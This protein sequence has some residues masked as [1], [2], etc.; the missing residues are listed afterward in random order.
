MIDI[1]LLREN[2]EVIK[3]ALKNRGVDLDVAQLLELDKKK[4]GMI[5]E[6]ENL[7]A[8][9]NEIS[10]QKEKPADL[11]KAKTIKEELKKKE[12]ELENVEKQFDSLFMLI[13]NIPLDDVPIGKSEKD[14]KVIREWGKIPKFDFEIKDHLELGKQLNL[15]DIKRAAKISGSRFGILKNEAVLLEF[16]L[17]QFAF[18]TLLKQGFTLIVPPTLLKTEMMKGMGYIDTK[19]DREE[20][21]FLEKDKL[22]LAATSEQM[23]GPMHQGEILE[24]KDLPKRYA[25][26]SSCFR[27]EAGSYGKDTKGI[28]RVHQFDKIEMFSFSKPE[29]SRKEHR[30]LIEL[31]EKL[32]QTIEIPYRVVHNCTGDMSRPSASTF[33]IEAWIPSQEKYREIQSAANCTDFQARRLKIRYKEGDKTNFVHTLNATAF[34]IGRTL[35]AI[36]ENYQQKDGRILVPKALK[37][38]IGFKYISN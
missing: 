37:K 23:L 17:I 11:E 19:E 6:V 38:H 29:D 2:P 21:Y 8:Q 16:A 9:R 24:V 34:A 1:K 18:D 25:A 7:R 3:Q 26:F 36:L 13:P 4:R 20:R 32:I 30:F 22:Y 10:A 28:F 31:E 12:K 33:D 5:Q 15:I 14:N 35:I 27:E